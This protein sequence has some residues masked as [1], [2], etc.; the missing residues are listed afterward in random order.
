MYFHRK[1]TP[2]VTAENIVFLVRAGFRSDEKQTLSFVAAERLSFPQLQ[3]AATAR[4]SFWISFVNY[5]DLAVL[6]QAL[7]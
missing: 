5:E 1:H 7:V 4:P 6:S 3:E 2:V